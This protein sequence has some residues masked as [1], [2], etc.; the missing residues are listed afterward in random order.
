MSRFMCLDSSSML[1]QSR[2]T[3]HL[4]NGAPARFRQPPTRRKWR[5]QLAGGV[6]RELVL[7]QHDP[8]EM[9]E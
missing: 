2:A 3:P 9:I 6:R 4:Y 1:P 7:A 5:A 8:V